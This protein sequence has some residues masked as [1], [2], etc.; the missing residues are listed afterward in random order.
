M[1]VARVCSIDTAQIIN[2]AS[3]WISLD[4][5]NQNDEIE[6]RIVGRGWK[7]EEKK[8]EEGK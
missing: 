8:G 3:N 6:D 4:T 2:G 1:P 5:R 7:K